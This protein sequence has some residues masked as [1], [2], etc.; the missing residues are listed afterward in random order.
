MIYL[1]Q[2][3]GILRF[4]V[5]LKLRFVMFLR[6][7]FSQPTPL[8]KTDLVSAPKP[9]GVVNRWLVATKDR[10]VEVRPDGE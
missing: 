7:V 4:F 5:I 2:T 6:A 1:G 8:E 3:S 9:P 10:L